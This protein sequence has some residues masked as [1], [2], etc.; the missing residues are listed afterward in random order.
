VVRSDTAI[1]AYEAEGV[2]DAGLT[3]ASMLLASYKVTPEIAPMVRLG[4]VSSSPPAGDAAVALLNP[5]VGGTWSPAIGPNLKLAVFLGVTIPI[6][7]GGGDAPDQ[8][9]RAA[10]GAGVLSRSAM[11]NAMFAV[12]YLTIFP[13]IGFAFV[14]SG[15]TLQVEATIFELVRVRG[16]DADA[17]ASRTNLTMGLHAGYFVAPMISV[18]ADLRFQQWL[19]SEQFLDDG[20]GANDENLTFAVGPRLH[21]QLADTVWLRPGLAYARGIDDPL[22]GAGYH[23]VQ[24]DLPVSF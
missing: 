17:D 12:N 9:T 24:I 18:G 11:D 16:E 10:L 7:S 3:I 22:S 6:G 23:V 21:L 20:K 2:D 15:L 19:V 8:A 14:R 1:A 4:L 5:V 13:G